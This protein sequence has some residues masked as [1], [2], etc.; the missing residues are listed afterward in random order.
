MPHFPLGL[1]MGMMLSIPMVLA[2]LAFLYYS[3]KPSALAP[4]WTPE[5]EVGEAADPALKDVPE[6]AADPFSAATPEPLTA[7]HEPEG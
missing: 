4:P 5:P 7:F 2:G 6:I 1:T 3:R